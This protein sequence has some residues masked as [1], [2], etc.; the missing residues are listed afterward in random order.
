MSTKAMLREPPQLQSNC[1][2]WVFTGGEHLLRGE[3]V[4]LI[5]DDN[6]YDRVHSPESNDIAIYRDQSGYITHTGLVRGTLSGAV[7][8]ESKWGIGAL[9][10]HV[11]DEQPYGKNIE[12]YRTN[13]GSH[14]IKTVST[15]TQPDASLA[16]DAT[17]K[18]LPQ[19]IR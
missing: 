5:L 7:M 1:H 6:G 19:T 3:D 14:H 2:G 8:V 12:Y 17:T 9:Y 15:D 11:A 4:Q 16:F 18:R 13:R 10:L